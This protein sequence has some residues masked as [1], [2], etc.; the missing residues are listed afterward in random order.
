MSALEA[1]ALYIVMAAMIMGVPLKILSREL[2]SKDKE[3]PGDG[4]VY[5]HAKAGGKVEIHTSNSTPDFLARPEAPSETTVYIKAKGGGWF[6]ADKPRINGQE[7]G[8]DDLF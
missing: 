3:H 6:L 1:I 8:S 2:N 7:P 5:V 4:F